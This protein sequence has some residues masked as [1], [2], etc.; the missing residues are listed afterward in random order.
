MGSEIEKDRPAEASG[1]WTSSAAMVQPV[2]ILEDGPVD[3]R[4][5]CFERER[6]GKQRMDLGIRQIA[7][8]RPPRTP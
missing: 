3:V 4:S 6:A 7:A 8:A 2:E 1:V 5:V